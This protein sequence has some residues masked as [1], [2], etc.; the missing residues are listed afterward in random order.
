MN[1]KEKIEEKMVKNREYEKKMEKYKEISVLRES[2]KKVM[3]Y[4]FYLKKLSEE[5]M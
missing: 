3:W 4:Y 2:E 5:M 1:Y